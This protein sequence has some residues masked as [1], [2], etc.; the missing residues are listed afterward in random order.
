MN[1]FTNV[2]FIIYLPFLVASAY[3]V[4]INPLF[5]LHWLFG[6]LECVLANHLKVVY[7]MRSNYHPN[8]ALSLALVLFGHIL[9]ILKV[10]QE[11]DLF[12]EKHSGKVTSLDI[13]NSFLKP[14]AYSENIRTNSGHYAAASLCM[15]LLSV[16][17]GIR[18]LTCHHNSVQY[19]QDVR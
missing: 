16:S 13:S 15:D 12:G 7:E 3:F 8:H 10:W 9:F 6:S 4:Y 2:R 19:L 17:I 11:I 18:L 1:A 5:H 14:I